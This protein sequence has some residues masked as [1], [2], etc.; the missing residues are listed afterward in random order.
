MKISV[1]GLGYVGLPTAVVIADE[2]YEVLGIDVDDQVVSTINR[3]EIH[4]VEPGLRSR[5]KTLVEEGNLKASLEREVSDVYIIAVPTPLNEQN[6]PDISFIKEA[7]L[8]LNK[9]LK[10]GDLIILESTSPIGTTEKI[11][12]W[13]ASERDDLK[14]PYFESEEDSD[15][16]IAH[17]PERVLP[18]NVLHE[19]I[20]N[21]RIVGGISK[22]SS[23]HAEAFYKTFTKGSCLVTNSRLAEFTKLA[24]NAFRDV[25]IAFSNELSVISDQVGVNVW[26][27]IELA[28]KHPRV[29]ILRPGPGVGGHCIAVDPL[30]IA[31]SAPE[32]SLLIQTARKI[33]DS[34][35]NVIIE[36]IKSL[37]SK[38]KSDIDSLTL[39]IF[40][41]SYKPDID[42]LRESPA[43][44]IAKEITKMNF[45]EIRIIEP[46]LEQKPEI[47]KKEIV[48]N[49]TLKSA[50]DSDIVVL[51]VAHSKF[52]EIKDT[53]INLENFIDAC[54]LLEN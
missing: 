47:F 44:K 6:K 16:Y 11:R 33:N 41:L 20:Y 37:V 22:E 31:D 7:V 35:P 32:D 18:G 43:L 27:L 30:F 51:L 1:I 2:G 49:D 3:G 40:G 26:D 23:L 54:G 36:K 5:V 53:A 13:I 9:I 24:E 19:I 29:N 42:D 45:K 4:I 48:F 39:S 34:K 8:H 50:L 15:L 38:K 14:V 25:N 17:C 46:H 21:D 12:Q 28:N 10:K 52:Q